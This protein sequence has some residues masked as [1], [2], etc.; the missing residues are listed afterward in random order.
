M[1]IFKPDAL[2]PKCKLDIRYDPGDCAYCLSTVVTSISGRT[3][4]KILPRGMSY[5]KILKQ[6]VIWRNRMVR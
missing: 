2:P 1:A 4:A 6:L 3:S 5:N